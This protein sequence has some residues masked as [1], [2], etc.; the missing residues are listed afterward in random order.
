[1]AHGLP[2]ISSRVGGV[3]EF[4]TDE[5]CGILIRPGPEGESELADAIVKLADDPE[6]RARMGKTARKRIVDMNLDW[7]ANAEKTLEIYKSVIRSN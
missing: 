6:L 4:I 3:S 7:T 5:S 2:C 1:M